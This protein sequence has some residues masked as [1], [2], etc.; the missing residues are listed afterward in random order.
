MNPLIVGLLVLTSQSPAPYSPEAT[1]TLAMK[2]FD[3]P[4]MAVAVVKDGRVVSAER[5]RGE[6]RGPAR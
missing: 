1:V 6:G 5:V 2:A 3:V 4:G